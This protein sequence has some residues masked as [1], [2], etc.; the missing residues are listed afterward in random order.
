MQ[1]MRPFLFFEYQC[2]SLDEF[3][4]YIFLHFNG[5]FPVEHGLA[6]VYCS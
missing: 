5:H 1:K 3:V 6:G 4:I 2:L